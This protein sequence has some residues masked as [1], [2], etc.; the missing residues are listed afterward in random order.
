MSSS[1]ARPSAVPERHRISRGLLPCDKPSISEVLL[2]QLFP[3]E[4]SPLTPLIRSSTTAVASAATSH[5]ATL[6]SVLNAGLAASKAARER[7]ASIIR[8]VIR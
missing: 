2:Y 3:L 4:E 1:K 8:P 5:N 6:F 7:I